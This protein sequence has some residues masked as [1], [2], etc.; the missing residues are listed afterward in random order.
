MDMFAVLGAEGTGAT[1]RRPNS[2]VNVALY[3][4]QSGG[5]SPR[6][7]GPERPYAW[8]MAF[9]MRCKTQTTTL[10]DIALNDRQEELPI[11]D[12]C[13]LRGA[14]EVRRQALQ[15]EQL[16]GGQHGCPAPRC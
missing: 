11:R 9:K 6:R 2:D 1:G 12:T 13:S 4:M 14:D 10:M 8:P 16:F 3:P 7:T 15:A 5:H